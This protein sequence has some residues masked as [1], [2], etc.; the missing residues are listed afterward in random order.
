[1]T[2]NVI[3]KTWHKV[4]GKDKTTVPLKAAMAGNNTNPST[5]GN[6]GNEMAMPTQSSLPDN[7]IPLYPEP[8]NTDNTQTVTINAPITIQAG[9]D[10]DEKAIA[11][12]V[13]H[14]LNQLMQD[15]KQRKRAVNYDG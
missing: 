8:H 5:L 15:N 14:A 12:E 6:L 4:F 7:V 1:M 2:D 10:M 3:N 13:K 11:A 9:H